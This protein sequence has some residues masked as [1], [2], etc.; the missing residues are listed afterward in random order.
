[1]TQMDADSETGAEWLIN[2]LCVLMTLL[3]AYF[4]LSA[5]RYLFT[6]LALNLTVTGMPFL[7]DSDAL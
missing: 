4:V 7:T 6:I 3:A 1:M 2:F 5:G